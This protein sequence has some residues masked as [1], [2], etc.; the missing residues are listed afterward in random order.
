MFTIIIRL[1][2]IA[3]YLFSNYFIEHLKFLYFWSVIPP[4]IFLAI[5]PAISWIISTISPIKS[6]SIISPTITWI[7]SSFLS[8]YLQHILTK[9][10][11]KLLQESLCNSLTIS[12]TFFENFS[13]NSTQISLKKS[14][15]IFL[16]NSFVN[17]FKNPSGG[18]F[19]GISHGMY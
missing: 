5:L 13:R 16:R 4:N 17:I 2:D 3:A 7:I 10:F 6:L 8:K 15:N 9:N 14:S 11:L 19:L 12:L 1:P 18:A